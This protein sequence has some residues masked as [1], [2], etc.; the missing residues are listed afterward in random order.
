MFNFT[1]YYS[2][3]DFEYGYNNTNN[4]NHFFSAKIGEDRAQWRDKTKGLSRL[5]IESN[6]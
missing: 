1:A 4:N 5:V 3:L 2:N 6:A